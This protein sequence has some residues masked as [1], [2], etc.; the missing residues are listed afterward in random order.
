MANLTPSVPTLTPRSASLVCPAHAS[1]AELLQ[2]C[3][4]KPTDIAAGAQMPVLL[5]KVQAGQSLVHEGA[6]AD[7]VFFVRSGTF[8]V[9]RTDEDGYEQVLA[10]AMRSEVLG[11]DA[12]CMESYPAAMQ[13]LEDSSVYVIP[14][15]EIAQ[16][17]EVLPSFSLV[18]QKAGSQK[19]IHSRDLVDILAAVDADVRLAR[20]LIHLS[21]RMAGCGQSPRLFHLRMGRR[22]IASLLGVA[23]ETVSRCFSAL[24]AMR[25]LNV[26]NREIEILDL[27]GLTDFSRSTRRQAD[28]ETSPYHQSPF[29]HATHQHTLQCAL[30]A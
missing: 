8:K 18:L 6:D 7:T 1:M 15:R 26:K 13:A 22:E 29:R 10:F 30:V 14:R 11:F 28:G 4:A 20:F 9:F 16:I 23:H 27:S 25:L 3:G 12:L 5:R 24:A 17:S 21:R 19:L 2:M